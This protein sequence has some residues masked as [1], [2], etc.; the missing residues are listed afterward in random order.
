MCASRSAVGT[1]EIGEC[2][3]ET[4]RGSAVRER[5]GEW[6]E[7]ERHPGGREAC[8]TRGG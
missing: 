4:K 1:V 6:E 8:E 3:R 2:E 7:C 5:P